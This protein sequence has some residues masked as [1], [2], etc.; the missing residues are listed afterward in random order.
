MVHKLETPI[1]IARNN[2]SKKKTPFFSQPDY[3][4]WLPT[5]SPKD[6]EIKY[7]KGL[8]A[9]VDDEYQDII[10]NPRLTLISTD[11][12]SAES[13]SAWFGKDSEPRKVELLR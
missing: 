1:V 7:K 10:Q 6:W 5:V 8:S 3:A 13:L 2:R 9:L 12:R 4:K 11:E